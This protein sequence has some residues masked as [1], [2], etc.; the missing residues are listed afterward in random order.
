MR[1]LELLA[2]SLDYI[3]KHLNRSLKTEDVAAICYCSK[4]TLEKLYHYV[5]H[6]SVHRYVTCRKMMAAARLLAENP[7]ASILTV[8]LEYGYGSHEAF[9]RAFKDVWNCTPSAFRSR[10]KFTEVYPRFSDPLQDPLQKGDIYLM[11]KRDISQLY[12]LF[13]ERK[14]C[15]FVCCDIESLTAINQVSQKAGD[16][17]ILEAIQR[18]NNAAGEEDF[19]F[20]IGGDEFCILTDSSSEEYAL[21]LAD[22]IRRHNAETYSFEGRQFPLSLHITVTKSEGSRLQYGELF[23][24]LYMAIEAIRHARG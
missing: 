1:G 8:A 12:E 10:E 16:L 15:Y 5:Y 13:Q 11:Q 4:S 19:V 22:A 2:C 17:A 6:T 21:D 24:S 9:T 7:E 20:R 3:E 14:D 18:M 23:T